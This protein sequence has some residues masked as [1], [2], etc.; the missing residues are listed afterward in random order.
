MPLFISQ[1]TNLPL[2]WICWSWL[3]LPHNFW[4][5]EDHPLHCVSRVCHQQPML[6]A[7]P[8]LF[9]A[10][11][12]WCCFSRWVQRLSQLRS[13][14]RAS[15]KALQYLTGNISKQITW[16]AAGLLALAVH[17]INGNYFRVEWSHTLHNAHRLAYYN[18]L[19]QWKIVFW[20]QRVG[21]LANILYERV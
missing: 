5:N 11:V 1:T 17:G 19:I 13:D 14:S 8:A 2:I 21:S 4:K 6:T 16:F 20:E 15:K 18:A 9:P 10:Q 3:S 12:G 7:C